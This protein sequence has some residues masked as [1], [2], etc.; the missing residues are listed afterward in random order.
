MAVNTFF[1]TTNEQT[2]GAAVVK[3]AAGKCKVGQ[4][5][6]MT[7]A[8]V[9]LLTANGCDIRVGTVVRN[10]ATTPFVWRQDTDS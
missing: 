6:E 10:L 5:I 8:E 9:P 2:N 1:G 4:P 3:V 7:L